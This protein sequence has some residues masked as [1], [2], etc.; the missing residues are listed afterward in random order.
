[1]KHIAKN[2]T[3]AHR[4]DEEKWTLENSATLSDSLLSVS[5]SMRALVICPM[6]PRNYWKLFAS[7]R[8]KRIFLARLEFRFLV[9][10]LEYPEIIVRKGAFL[11][12]PR[13]NVKKRKSTCSMNER[14]S[15]RARENEREREWERMRE[16]KREKKREGKERKEKFKKN[17]KI[18]KKNKKKNTAW[19]RIGSTK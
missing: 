19:Y 13:R 1:M 11:I 16:R 4:Y 9:F 17:K 14:A 10:P 18:T 3:L 5:R 15:E 12:L 6:E 7:A 2:F 8:T